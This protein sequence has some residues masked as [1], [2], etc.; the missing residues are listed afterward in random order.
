LLPRV[1][2][3]FKAA[4]LSFASQEEL[5]SEG[6]AIVMDL[7]ATGRISKDE[8]IRFLMQMAEQVHPIL[9]MEMR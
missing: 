3:V 5:V 9:L 4:D 1:S 6:T 8:Y 2:D 7:D